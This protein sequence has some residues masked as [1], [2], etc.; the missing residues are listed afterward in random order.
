MSKIAIYT[1]AK[2][3]EKFI[4]RWHE[5]AKAADYLIILDT[6]YYAAAQESPDE[7]PRAIAVLRRYLAGCAG[8]GH[9][10]LISGFR[11]FGS[12][13]MRSLAIQRR[14]S[15]TARDRAAGS[16]SPWKRTSII[17]GLS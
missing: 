9:S 5:P 12:G 13:A 14:A 10:L 1:I 7:R 2:N 11:K 3:E 4:E 6:G 8:D 17:R 15:R 16:P